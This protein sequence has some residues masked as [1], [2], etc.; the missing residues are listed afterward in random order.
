MHGAQVIAMWKPFG[1][2]HPADLALEIFAEQMTRT[3]MVLAPSN[4]ALGPRAFGARRTNAHQHVAQIWARN[5]VTDTG[6]N[7]APLANFSL[8]A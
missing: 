7:P 4:R 2:G 6:S 8:A 3:A 5:P 1:G